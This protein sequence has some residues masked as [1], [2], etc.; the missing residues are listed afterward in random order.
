MSDSDKDILFQP[1]FPSSVGGHSISFLRVVKSGDDCLVVKV[2]NLLHREGEVIAKC[3]IKEKF[4]GEYSFET[5][6][7]NWGHEELCLLL[8]EKGIGGKYKEWLLAKEN[9]DEQMEEENRYLSI[10]RF[11]CNPIE[12]KET[13]GWLSKLR[14]AS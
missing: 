9:G 1:R 11:D 14:V 12:E 7:E 13:K 3:T 6:R 8:R 4:S 2:T 10:I 5:T